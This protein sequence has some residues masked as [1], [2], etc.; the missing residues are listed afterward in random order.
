MAD[1]LRL[2][3]VLLPV[4]CVSALAQGALPGDFE[5]SYSL[6]SRGAKIAKMQRVFRR[7]GN[8]LYLYR[9]ETRT[10]GLIALFRKDHIVEQSTWL[11][12]KDSLRPLQ[13][14]YEHNGGS[15]DRNVAVIFDWDTRRITNTVNGQSWLIPAEPDV[16]DKLLYQFAVMYDLRSGRTPQRYTIAD[17]GKIKSYDFQALGEETIETPLGSLQTLKFSR[18]REGSDRETTLWCAPKLEFLPV[19]VENIEKDGLTTV[20][21][22]D[23]VTGLDVCVPATADDSRPGSLSCGD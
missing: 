3:L 10:T 23:T 21:V 12:N 9:S 19:K 5:A 2:L 7:L 6:Y 13:Y 17:G 11:L 15:K 14:L 1:T 20:A 16:M 22:I 4:W 8:G 18:H